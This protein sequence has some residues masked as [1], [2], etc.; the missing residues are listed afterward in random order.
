MS[1]HGHPAGVIRR[2]SEIFAKNGSP[3]NGREPTR[4]ECGKTSSEPVQFW[5]TFRTLNTTPYR[6]DSSKFEVHTQCALLYRT[7]EK[8]ELAQEV[9]IHTQCAPLH[10]TFK[11]SSHWLTKY[12][13]IRTVPACIRFPIGQL[14]AQEVS[15][16]TQC[17]LVYPTFKFSTLSALVPTQKSRYM[18]YACR[19]TP[20]C[21]GDL[22]IFEDFRQ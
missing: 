3:K 13:Y 18:V 12:R 22:S 17:A 7:Q 11:L 6:G 2:S 8:Q 15:I 5:S 4:R 19:Y 9:S 16:H 20:P 14:L 21:R 1:P 10:R